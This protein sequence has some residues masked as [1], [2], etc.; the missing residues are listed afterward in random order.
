MPIR[1][2]LAATPPLGKR[3]ILSTV[4]LSLAPEHVLRPTLL[5]ANVL[6]MPMLPARLFRQLSAR[7]PQLRLQVQPAPPLQ[8]LPPRVVAVGH[9]IRASTRTL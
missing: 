4:F 1:I 5:V 7:R 3:R 8:Q 6:S 9:R 2:P